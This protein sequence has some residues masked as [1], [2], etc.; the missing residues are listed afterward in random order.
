MITANQSKSI[1]FIVLTCDSY[2]DLW[3]MFINFHD[4]FW[5]NC[6][7]DKYFVTNNKSISNSSFEF[8]NIGK[9]DSWSDGL[10]KAL[11]ILK[12]KYEYLIITLEDSPLVKPV[13]Q[14]KLDLILKSFFD[15]KGNFLSLFT[16]NNMG[17]PTKKFNKYFGILDKG[18]LYR[19]TCVYSFWKISVLE[20]LLVKE[21]NA[22]EFERN[23]SIR[24]DKYDYFFMT[25]KNFF[26]ISNTV[27]KGKWL[28]SEYKKIKKL[29]F[30]PDISARKLNTRREEI[31]YKSYA[32]LFKILYK[33]LI[34]WKIKRSLIFKLRGYKYL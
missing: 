25:Y 26:K 8:I 24:S 32:L 31:Y 18:M 1:A 29:G 20:N 27:I 7:Y 23:G 3:P 9:D 10:L 15:E 21:E 13:E 16:Q 28:I 19:P 11:S 33:Y 30:E 34:P 17:S 12:I 14:E 4:K 22:W 2:S 5:P 6:P